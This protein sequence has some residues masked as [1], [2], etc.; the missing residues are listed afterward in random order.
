M[1][2]LPRLISSFVLQMHIF[3]PGNESAS[4]IL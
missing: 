4:P 2:A 3:G 1:R